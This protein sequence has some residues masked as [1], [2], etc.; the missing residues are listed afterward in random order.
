MTEETSTLLAIFAH[1]DDE[2]FRPGGTLALLARSKVKVHVLTLTHGEAGS[3]G[4]P[5]LCTPD[6]LSG[7]R[8]HELRCACAALGIEPPHLLS[9]PDGGLTDADPERVEADIL[10]VACQVHPQVLL[11][12]GPD[13]LSGHP[14]HIA[15]GQ[16]AAKAYSR[17]EDIAALYT[18]AVSQS[19]VTQ[20][21]INQLRPVRDEMITLTVDVSPVWE[22][23]QAAMRCHATQWSSS[24]MLSAPSE[25]Q[26][27]FFGQEHF[28]R[29]AVRRCD[30]DF[31]PEILQGE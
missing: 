24:P 30:A 19:L 7:V 25:R 22:M 20:M 15:V 21:G 29:S 6:D 13:G 2:T 17:V 27:L 4:E 8:E 11:S 23:K 9:Y 1:P 16:W 31:L 18:V 26:R 14:D 10:A 5:A 3:C 28:V 12:F